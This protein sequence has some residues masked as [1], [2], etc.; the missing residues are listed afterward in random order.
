M[1]YTIG[2][3]EYLCYGLVKGEER[4]GHEEIIAISCISRGEMQFSGTR[5]QNT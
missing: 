5:N 1:C 4:K 3:E 2:V